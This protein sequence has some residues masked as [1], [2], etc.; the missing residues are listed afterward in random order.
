MCLNEQ[1]SYTT[2]RDCTYQIKRTKTTHVV[3][4]TFAL[5]QT[6]LGKEKWKN[7]KVLLDSGVSAT[8]VSSS[9]VR[10]L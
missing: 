2:L 7:M 6:R 9:L 4:I 1:L 8:V 10:K 5:F 3:P